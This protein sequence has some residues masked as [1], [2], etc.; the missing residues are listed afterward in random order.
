MATVT[1]QEAQAHLTDL[2]HALTPGDEVVILAAQALVEGIPAVTADA[3][4]DQYG[5]RRIWQ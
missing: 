5:V 2:V 4:F 3:I 1:I